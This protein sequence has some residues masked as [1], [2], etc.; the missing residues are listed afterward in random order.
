MTSSNR[1]IFRVTGPLWASLASA[2]L[3]FVRG[4]YQSPVNSPHK[5]QWRGALYFSLIC[6]WLDDS[7]NH[8]DP[9]DLRRHRAHY[10]VTV[11]GIQLGR[12]YRKV[13]IKLITLILTGGTHGYGNI[14]TILYYTQNRLNYEHLI[15]QFKLQVVLMLVWFYQQSPQYRSC[16]CEWYSSTWS[17]C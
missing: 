13:K 7:A 1:N 15:R 12:P 8:R 2:S 17:T 16:I 14:Y 4:I 3:A 5:G 9:G 6:A 11:M 10:D